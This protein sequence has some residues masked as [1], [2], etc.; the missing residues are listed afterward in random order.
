M[1]YE[2]LRKHSKPHKSMEYLWNINLKLLA[3]ELQCSY[4]YLIDCLN[5]SKTF[6]QRLEKDLWNLIEIM[7][8][9]KLE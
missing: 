9:E 2:R 1:L 3:K 8:K 7:N 4:T 5:G 6:G